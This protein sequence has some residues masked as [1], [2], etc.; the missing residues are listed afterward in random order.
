ML[1]DKG[2]RKSAF[3]VHFD[4][5]S[6]QARRFME[7]LQGL[8]PDSPQGE[9]LKEWNCRYSADSRGAFL[10][11]QFYQ[12]LYREVFGKGGVG[13]GVIDYLA[14]ET[15]LFVDFYLNFDRVLLAERSAW[16]G[17]ET[18]NEL[19]RRVAAEALATEPKTW[20]DQRQYMMNHLLLGGKLPRLL[21]FDRGP[22]TAIGSR[23]TIHQGQIY[24]SS[25]RDTTFV[26]SFRLV[27]D[28]AE[29]GCYSNLAGG[30]SDRRFSRWYC[31]DL[32][33][34]IS[35]EYKKIEGLSPRV[36]HRFP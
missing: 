24:R 8:L 20:G 4:V 21:G 35:G 1:V 6:I 30:P 26:P 22:V 29:D 5:Y 17:D 2:L 23:A 10:F 18:R 25:G 19:F 14:D 33:A 16:F 7:I 28:L 13:Q 15:G 31:S 27:M 9:I 32:G 34:W 11:E 12:S 36:A 3:K